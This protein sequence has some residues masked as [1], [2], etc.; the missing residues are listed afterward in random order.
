[1]RGRFDLTEPDGTCYLAADAL[2]AL[3]EIVGPE[4]SNGIV[5]ADL[6]RKRRLLRVHLPGKMSLADTTSRPGRAA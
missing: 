2:A 3:I 1:M 5:A 4:S 6:L